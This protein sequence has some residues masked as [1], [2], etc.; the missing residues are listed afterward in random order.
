MKDSESAYKTTPVQLSPKHTAR[1]VGSDGG[2]QVFIGCGHPIQT[3]IQT[4]ARATK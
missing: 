4:R 1:K 3:P 2:I